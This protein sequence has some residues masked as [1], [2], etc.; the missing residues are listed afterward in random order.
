MKPYN[1]A[2]TNGFSYI[3]ILTSDHI[4]V[5]KQVAFI[6]WK[7]IHEIVY[8]SANQWLLLFGNNYF[9]SNNWAETIG[10]YYIDIYTSDHIIV[11]EQMAF[12]MW[13]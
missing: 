11:H 9:K 2:Q 8:L 1:C 10:F 5:H 4:I 13:K 3:E 7:Y 12:I 6:I